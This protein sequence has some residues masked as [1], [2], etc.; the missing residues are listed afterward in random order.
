[1]RWDIVCLHKKKGGLGV[2]SL[3]I[4]NKALLSKCSWHYATKKEALWKR[5]INGM[6]GGEE[7]GDV[8][9]RLGRGLV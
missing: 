9:G 4:L 1:M 5:V 2:K 8:L 3:S 7:G 6:Y